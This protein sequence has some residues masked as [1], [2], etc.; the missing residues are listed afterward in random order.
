[1]HSKFRPN[2]DE[3]MDYYADMRTYDREG[4]TIPSQRRYVR[5]YDEVVHFGMPDQPT[6]TLTSITIQTSRYVDPAKAEPWFEVLYR[7]HEPLFVSKPQKP[8]PN[9]DI[10]IEIPGGI[11]VKADIKVVFF[12][13]SINEKKEMFHCWFNTAFIENN[14][15]VLKKPEIDVAWKDKNKKFR[16]DF[17]IHFAF[18]PGAEVSAMTKLK[19]EVGSPSK[20]KG[21]KKDRKT[22]EMELAPST[23]GSSSN[24]KKEKK[25]KKK[26]EEEEEKEKE[27]EKEQSDSEQ[28]E[29]VK[30]APSVDAQPEEKKEETTTTEKVEGEKKEKRKSKKNKT[31]DGENK[32]EEKIPEKSEEKVV[33]DS[34]GEGGKRK[35]KKKKS[36]N[37]VN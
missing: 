27:K 35:S 24:G 22:V 33:A 2:A 26:E 36:V 21:K 25:G 5:Y 15:L 10:T 20:K 29:K 14:E 11:L 32:V 12:D 16:A 34:N 8:Q 19:Q 23:E 37:S 9:K 1:L 4:V 7:G 31:T 18:G 13:R 28:E 6:L 3:A 17:E 30:E